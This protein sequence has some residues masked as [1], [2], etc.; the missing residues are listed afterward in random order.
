VES[1]KVGQLC[2][3]L[4]KWPIWYK[5]KKEG[6]GEEKEV[7]RTW[8]ISDDYFSRVQ[9]GKGGDIGGEMQTAKPTEREKREVEN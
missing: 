8:A 5:G 6:K 4:H 7:S 1:T 9:D 2:V 3:H